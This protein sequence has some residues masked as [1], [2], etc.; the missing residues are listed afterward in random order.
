MLPLRRK[1]REPLELQLTAMIDIFA[2]LVIFLLKGTYF[3]AVEV[4]IPKEMTL[5]E[6]VSKESVETSPKVVIA[7]SEVSVPFLAPD[8]VRIEDVES[9]K[10]SLKK[11]VTALPK[12]SGPIA[13]TLSVIA[14]KAISYK[15]IY[16]VV[17][18]FREAGFG[19]VLFIA[20]GSNEGS[21]SNGA[22]H[23]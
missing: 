2:M 10:P 8:P 21:E 14:D 3:G 11:Y 13:T 18:V 23:E 12:D 15:K 16:D 22:R 17:K 19:N 20:S 9:L 7:E 1:R 4:Q 6:S 5:P